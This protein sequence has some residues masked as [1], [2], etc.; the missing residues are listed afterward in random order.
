MNIDRRDFLKSAGTVAAAGAAAGC[1]SPASTS[2]PAAR[3]AARTL[4]TGLARGL[5]LLTFRSQGRDQLGVK[6]AKG[7]LDVA[8]AA[9]LLKMS[10]PATMD[11]L[12][13]QADGPSVQAVVEA[14]LNGTAA[15]AAFRPEDG[16][17]YGA[18]V[19]RPDKIVCVG[20][21][22]RRHAE[23][24]GSPIPEYP[25]LFDKF[26][27]SG[28][29]RQPGDRVPRQRR[30]AAGVEHLGLHLQDAHDDQLHLRLFHTRAR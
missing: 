13:Q 7:I 23:E 3:A 15:Q 4:G 27:G 5:T 19:S 1:T 10:A 30:D 17:E 29:P 11:E 8:Q 26:N 18:L 12:L 2:P 21:N 6:T 9:T 25:G 14:A 24:I 16:L 28:R 20:L 22:C